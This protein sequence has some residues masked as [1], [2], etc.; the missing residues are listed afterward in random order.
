LFRS[1]LQQLQVLGKRPLES[2][3]RVFVRTAFPGFFLNNKLE[4]NDLTKDPNGD[5]IVVR[6][7]FLLCVLSADEMF[8]SL[9]TN[10]LAM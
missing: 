7:L 5:A 9:K 1:P 4:K 10:R 6:H 8:E 2:Y 3:L